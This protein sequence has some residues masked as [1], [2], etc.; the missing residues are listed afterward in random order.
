MYDTS[1]LEI[2]SEPTLSGTGGLVIGRRIDD[3][4]ACGN[5][6]FSSRIT[7]PNTPG[8]VTITV[9]SGGATAGLLTLNVV[10]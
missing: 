4:I 3:K 10:P 5:G 9:A 6:R 8:P 2:L 1:H 7:A